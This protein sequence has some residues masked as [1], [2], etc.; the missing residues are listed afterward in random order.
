MTLWLTLLLIW[1]AGIPAALFVAAALA[2]ALNERRAAR[3]PELAMPYLLRGRS[4]CGRRVHSSAQATRV[5]SRPARLH[6]GARRS[7]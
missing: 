1:T 2:A 7:A 5:G 6:A 4:A 3:F